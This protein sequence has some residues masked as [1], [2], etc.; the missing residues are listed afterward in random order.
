[1]RTESMKRSRRL[2]RSAGLF[3]L[4][5]AVSGC[6]EPL[7]PERDFLIRTPA[8]RTTAA[9]P[10]VYQPSPSSTESM[11]FEW[12]PAEG[13]DSYTITFWQGEDEAEIESLEVDFSAPLITFDVT[14]PTITEVP[15]NP[16]NPDDPR[17]VMLVRHEVPL[18]EI[19]AALQSAGIEPDAGR[20]YTLLSVF[21]KNGGDEWRSSSLT[22]VVFELKP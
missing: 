18:S 2:V 19:A 9:R 11:E 1:M 22:P 10:P 13:A 21:A 20:T 15:V 4:L 17:R 16:E 3:A 6:S 8:R 12:S 7:S 5:V 14:A